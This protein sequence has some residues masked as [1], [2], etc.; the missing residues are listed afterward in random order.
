MITVVFPCI[1]GAIQH[2]A[3]PI[4]DILF[5]FS[6]ESSNFLAVFLELSYIE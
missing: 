2:T 1:A 4:N 3:V 6:Y 5:S